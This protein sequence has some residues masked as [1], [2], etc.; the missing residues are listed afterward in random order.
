MQNPTPEDDG[1]MQLVNT[2]STDRKPGESEEEYLARL[3]E[4]VDS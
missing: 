2:H 3:S 1:L 4:E